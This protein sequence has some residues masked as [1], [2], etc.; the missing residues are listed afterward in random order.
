MDEDEM[1]L[2]LERNDDVYVPNIF[3]PNGDGVNDELIISGGNNIEGIAFFM[4]FDRWG[5][6]LYEKTD[7]IAG[8]IKWDGRFKNQDMN[9]GVYAYRLI[10]QYTDGNQGVSHGDVTLIR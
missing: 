10:V 6:V 4:I 2:F 3:S 7:V 5:N 8:E 9:P 1:T